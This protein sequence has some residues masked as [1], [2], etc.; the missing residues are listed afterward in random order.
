LLKSA[1]FIHPSKIRS[2][3]ALLAA[4]ASITQYVERL[5]LTIDADTLYPPL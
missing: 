1:A 5:S 2:Y 3:I 4:K